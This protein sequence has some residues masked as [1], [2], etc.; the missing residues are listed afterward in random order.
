MESSGASEI[1]LNLEA[2]EV[3][4]ISYGASDIEIEG[5][6]GNLQV[7]NTGASEVSLN[8]LIADNVEI[9][10]SGASSTCVHANSSLSVNVGGVSSVCYGGNPSS[11]DQ[12][13]SRMSSFEKH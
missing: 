13:V 11:V 7:K 12:E 9:Q 10:S 1:E 5:T 3:I 4:V 8:E 2:S 6:T